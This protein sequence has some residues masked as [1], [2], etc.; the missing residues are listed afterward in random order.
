M[1]GIALT[2]LYGELKN[3]STSSFFLEDY[4]DLNLLD[5]RIIK[6]QDPSTKAI[7]VSSDIKNEPVTTILNDG[8]LSIAWENEEHT[9]FIVDSY[10]YDLNL[11]SELDVNEVIE[12]NILLMER[13]FE[14]HHRKPLQGPT[15][16]TGP[17]ETVGPTGTDCTGGVG[18]T[19][20]T[21]PAGATSGIIGQT[22]AT[23][24]TGATG[25]GVTGAT[26]ST[27]NTGL[28]GD[29]GLTGATGFGATGVT[30]SIGLTGPTGVT[31]FGATGATSLT[32]NTGA[33][34]LIGGTG[35][36]GPTG[37][38]GATG[39]GVTGATGSTGNTGPTGATGA[40]GNIGATGITG[41]T[42][43][44]GPTGATGLIGN[45]TLIGNAPNSQ[46]ATLSGTE[47]TLQPANASFGGVVTTSAQTIAGPKTFNNNVTIITTADLILN[48]SATSQVKQ[49]PNRLIT[50]NRGVFFGIN[51]GNTTGTGFFNNGFGDGTLTSFTTG[52]QNCAFGNPDPILLRPTLGLLTTGN[53]NNVMGC[54][55]LTSLVDGSS[56]NVVGSNSLNLL[57]SGSITTSVGNNNLPLATVGGNIAIGNSVGSNLTTG[58]GNIMIGND[59]A[60]GLTTGQQ[61]LCIGESS[62]NII[63]TRNNNTYIGYQAGL[64]GNGAN[65]VFV[66]WRA[67]LGSASVAGV[68]GQNVVIGSLAAQNLTSG[69]FNTIVGG[70]SLSNIALA[71][72]LTSG[73]SNTIYGS[74][75]APLLTTGSNNIIIGQGAGNLITTGSTGICIGSP[76]SATPSSINIGTVG[77]HTSCAIAGISN[78]TS[79]SGVAVFVNAS[80]ELGTTTSSER[81]KNSIETVSDAI[82]RKIYDM[83]VVNFYYNDDPS[84]I[85]YGMIAEE[86][87]EILPEIV[88]RD[89]DEE[90]GLPR[91]IQYHL[92]Q[93]LMIKQLQAHQTRLNAMPSYLVSTIENQTLTLDSGI[94][95][96]M[97]S[98]G[99]TTSSALSNVE[100]VL[101]GKTVTIHIPSM[102]ISSIYGSATMIQ[103]FS[104]EYPLPS[105]FAP[106]QN[107]EFP[108]TIIQS[109]IRT[110]GFICVNNNKITLSKFD[111]S[112]INTPF[113][114]KGI[115]ITYILE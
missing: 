71:P 105:N 18:A 37:M 27:G 76:G 54:N 68:T 87:A 112:A 13:S 46:G 58:P 85:Q 95:T 5:R 1:G 52:Q 74:G 50:Y 21:G 61:N 104:D 41:A 51:S 32:G 67:G 6:S 109:D 12:K 55:S 78:Q 49:G 23:G 72:V 106:N 59:A 69:S 35:L 89:N 81:F 80:G 48:L 11:L 25:F 93:P 26:G 8:L 38:T 16:T 77:V 53:N 39:F 115:S 97:S 92:I 15:G 75:A 36:T 3:N 100:L 20:A 82:S 57:V 110:T 29:T 40:T 42:G 63:G 103:I 9:F 107:I 73:L 94:I 90:D 79:T 44:T 113:K 64:F 99:L 98:R 108:C 14:C 111:G 45:L 28:T 101:N 65:N 22:G 4:S 33:T 86:M 24:M 62:G 66:G 60:D 43:L 17:T 47:L 19:G 96:L 7:S 102:T 114:T 56:N 91:A 70:R 31:G 88:V 10:E 83:R 30:G 2:P 34:G 84:R